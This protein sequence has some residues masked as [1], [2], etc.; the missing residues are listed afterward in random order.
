MPVT[1]KQ[2][3]AE[4]G[5]SW[6]LVTR[7]LRDHPSVAPATRRRIQE[8]AQRLGYTE[9]SN[10]EARAL[11]ARRYGHRVKTSIVAVITP[12]HDNEPL[13]NAPFFSSLLDGI[14]L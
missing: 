4:L 1:Q 3:A 12:P 9:H 10:R 5:V 11:I 6:S 14:E 7:A 13:H 8:A 2:I